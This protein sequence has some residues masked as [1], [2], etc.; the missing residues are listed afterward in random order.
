MRKIVNSKYLHF[1]REACI[2]SF[3]LT[4]IMVLLG[5]KGL[6]AAGIELILAQGSADD[7]VSVDVNV[8]IHWF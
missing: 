3:F 5:T 4:S 1:A 7:F 8:V 2:S 6:F